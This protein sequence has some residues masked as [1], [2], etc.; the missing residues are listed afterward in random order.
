[1]RKTELIRKSWKIFKINLKCVTSKSKSFNQLQKSSKLTR[2][3]LKMVF[4]SK[5][6]MGAKKTS[7]MP[8]IDDV[9]VIAPGDQTEPRD[10]VLYRSRQFSPDGYDAV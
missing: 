10:I 1:M 7:N 8:Q 6:S 4:K 2:K 5:G 3:N 9:V